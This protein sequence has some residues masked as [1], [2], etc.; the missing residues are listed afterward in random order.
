MF[1]RHFIPANPVVCSMNVK[2]ISVVTVN[3]LVPIREREPLLV[4]CQWEPS[5]N[6]ACT[7]P[8]LVV[9]CVRYTVSSY[10]AGGSRY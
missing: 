3:V 7:I 8:Q 2:Y 10:A 1:M 6:S 5:T 9:P 4:F